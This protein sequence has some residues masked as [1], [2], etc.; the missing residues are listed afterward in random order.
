MRQRIGFIS[1]QHGVCCE[2]NFFVNIR[3][4][5]PVQTGAPARTGFDDR[6]AQ[7]YRAPSQAGPGNDI[8]AGSPGFQ[9]AP[10]RGPASLVAFGSSR[11]VPGDAGLGG[12]DF[13]GGAF[14]TLTALT[15]LRAKADSWEAPRATTSPVHGEG[16]PC[17]DGLY[18]RAWQH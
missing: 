5:G 18:S 17:Q 8:H 3:R 2:P 7:V 14:L 11:P 12:R 4:F 15:E 13:D 1:L 6:Q 10:T 16:A 9:K